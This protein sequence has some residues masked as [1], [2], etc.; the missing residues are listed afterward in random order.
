MRQSCNKFCLIACA[1]STSIG[2]IT[3]LGTGG[4]NGLTLN[5]GMAVCGDLIL[6][7]VATN[8]TGVNDLAVYITDR[9][10]GLAHILVTQG[11][12]GLC[13]NTITVDTGRDDLT[14]LST[15]GV[16]CYGLEGVAV[17]RISLLIFQTAVRADGF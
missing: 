1:T 14:S 2:G 3:L 5:I 13:L 12:D 16:S 9:L 10:E 4:L 11:L 15:G 17:S 7:A 8:G 6:I